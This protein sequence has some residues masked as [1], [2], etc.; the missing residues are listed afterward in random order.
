MEMVWVYVTYHTSTLSL[1][2]TVKDREVSRWQ[3]QEVQYI[4]NSLLLT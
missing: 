3:D 1:A 4:L 2:P